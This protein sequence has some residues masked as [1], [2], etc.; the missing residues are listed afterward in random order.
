MRT[1]AMIGTGYVGLVTG[2]CFAELGNHVVCLDVDA[3]KV[4][5][6]NGGGLPF[7]EPFLLELVTRNKA[8]GRLSFSTDLG[9]GI[10]AS[11]VIF[12][13]VGTPMGDDGHADLTAVRN[14]AQTIGRAINAPKIVAYKS[15]VP[16]Q[17][18]DL[19]VSIIDE[20]NVAGHAVHV[21]SNPEFLREGSAVADFM[22]PDRIVIGTDDADAQAV[23]AELYAPLDAPLVVVDVRTAEMIKYTSNAFLATKITFINEIANIC[24]LVGADIKAV[25]RGI[26][27]D[28]RIGTEFLNAGLGYGG[29]CFPKD[30]RALASL[31][32]SREYEPEL[33]RAVDE[34]NARQVPRNLD[35]LQ[36]ALGALAGKTIA[37]LGLAFKPNTDDTRDSPALAAVY[38]LL[39][40][41]AIVQ[42]HDP[43]ASA[44]VR[45]EMGPDANITF[46]AD[47]YEAMSGADAVLLATEWN[48]Y[49]TIDFTTV[50]SL[51]R[52]RVILDGRNIFDPPKV[53][54]AG[55]E[56][57]GV[58][59]PL[60]D[61]S[62]VRA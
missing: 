12:I 51:L 30:M 54:A 31:A 41:N 44:S 56:Y 6:L 2:A 28:H 3:A 53:R 38:G 23:L 49:K 37:V 11:E 26:G 20:F 52:G 34:V 9:T 15:T 17:T 59:R 43:V 14:A 40:R 58:G 32:A 60:Q 35:K 22:K 19:I 29:S 55:L 33:L 24:E 61:P 48:E 45:A 39:E 16:V 27:Y 10:A 13:A 46:H 18:G 50:R 25:C 42:A 21:V 4:D 5:L 62:Q 57:I 8:A 47:V 36:R 7:F 1:I